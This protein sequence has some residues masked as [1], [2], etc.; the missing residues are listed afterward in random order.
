[1]EQSPS[2]EANS[3]SATQEISRLLRNSEDHYSVHN[4]PILTCILNHTNLVHTVTHY[5]IVLSSSPI[6]PSRLFLSGIYTKT[7]YKLVTST[8][9]HSS[10][11]HWFWRQLLYLV[12]STNY[13][14][15]R[16]S[17]F[18][19]AP[20]STRLHGARTEMTVIF[21]LATVRT[22]NL[23]QPPVTFSLLDPNI[24]P[25]LLSSTH[26]IKFHTHTMQ[27]VEL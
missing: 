22:S 9:S 10:Y 15:S 26:N 13:E 4:S 27:Q 2:W 3:I 23:T 5:D 14:A 25:T 20:S 19:T 11:T 1:M 7:L 17:N 6:F 24:L 21:I 12:K 18:S 8:M 16:F